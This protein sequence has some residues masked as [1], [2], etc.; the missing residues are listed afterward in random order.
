VE[1]EI[2]QTLIYA[3]IFDYPLSASEVWKFLISQ[4]KTRAKDVQKMLGWMSTD[5]KLIGADDKYFFLKGRKEIVQ[6]RKKREFWSRP[7]I[8]LAEKIAGILRKIPWVEFIGISGALAMKNAREED[9]ID[10]FLITQKK[11]LWLT[12]FLAVVIVEFLGRRRRPQDKEVSD[13]ICLNMFLDED[14]L[15][16]PEKERDLFSSHEVIQVKPLWQKNDYYQEF[17]RANLWVRNYLANSLN[18]RGLRRKSLKEKKEN[19]L[20]SPFLDFLESLFYRIQVW[21]MRKRRTLE[22]VEPGRIRFHPKD[23]R[24]WVLK[25][26]Q[27]RK[28]LFLAKIK[29]RG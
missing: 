17:L 27:R 20:I 14:H 10:L 21:Y 5:L 28:N 1:K 29:E 26:Y 15:S 3:D 2:L 6:T 23:A 8:K 22:V 24:V 18:I 9:D 12:R 4:R 19:F 13:K 11:R 16:L 25:K 7:K